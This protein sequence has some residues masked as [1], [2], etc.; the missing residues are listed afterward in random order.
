MAAPS[1][2][3][4]GIPPELHDVPNGDVI[5]PADLPNGDG[6]IPEDMV[7]ASKK[8]MEE[9]HDE[10]EKLFDEVKIEPVEDDT[11]KM[12]K[13]AKKLAAIAARVASETAMFRGYYMD[14][15]MRGIINKEIELSGKYY[16]WRCYI[17][18]YTPRMFMFRIPKE[19]YCRIKREIFHLSEEELEQN[20]KDYDNFHVLNRRFISAD[21]RK[22]QK[23]R[24]KINATNK[25]G[26]RTYIKKGFNAKSLEGLKKGRLARTVVEKTVE[27]KKEDVEYDDDEERKKEQLRLA[28]KEQK[29]IAKEERVE[30]ERKEQ[31]EAQAKQ[32]EDEQHEAEERAK[33][34]KEDADREV[35]RRI[36]KEAD[37]KKRQEESDA[38]EAERVRKQKEFQKKKRVK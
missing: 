17:K 19:D 27:D 9:L 38:L 1:V 12:T 8:T 11:K 36:A 34:E 16:P 37:R 15:T 35:E 5:I 22:S 14:E 18:T 4:V 30:R 3:D 6:A 29:R 25:L 10:A 28:K 26:T 21:D 24:D 7:Q 31:K 33:K 20:F 2:D 23:Y 13:T 32:A